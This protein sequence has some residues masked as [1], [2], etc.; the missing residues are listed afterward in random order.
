MS[1]KQLRVE[2]GL[3]QAKCAE[4]LQIPVRTYKRYESDEGK[5]NRLKYE[6]IV[7]RLNSYGFIDEEHGKLTIEKIKE[8]C[9]GVFV[10]YPV[11]YC[12]LFGSYAKGK[13]T[14]TSDVDLLV[15]MP[16]D[17]LQYLELIEVLRE[18]LKKKVDLLDVTQLNNNP[19]L[20]QEIL[21][22]GVRIY[23]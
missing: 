21:K 16:I 17:G 13:E 18:E 5:I 11:D 2:K 23:G 20:M 1:L 19:A 6:S 7:N 14:E 22:D 8:I 4:Y 9:A 15:S 12:Y 10:K 3:S